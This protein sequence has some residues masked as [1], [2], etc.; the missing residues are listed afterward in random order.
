MVPRGPHDDGAHSRRCPAAAAA[1]GLDTP[2]LIAVVSPPRPLDLA[3]AHNGSRRPRRSTP[4]PCH[5]VAPSTTAPS[6]DPA[7]SYLDP[8]SPTPRRRTA[9]LSSP[10]PHV[11][12]VLLPKG[13]TE[14]RRPSPRQR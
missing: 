5:L 13:F 4:A 8:A 3:S 14:P 7:R 1:H 10:A 9:S 2:G 11:V 12:P 6:L